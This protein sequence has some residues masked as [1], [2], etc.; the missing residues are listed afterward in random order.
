M[1]YKNNVGVCNVTFG[2][3]SEAFQAFDD[4]QRASQYFATAELA[5]YLNI[6]LTEQQEDRL[7]CQSP[8]SCNHKVSFRDLWTT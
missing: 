3:V 4:I 2:Q 5:V 7:A 1:K 8:C 6:M